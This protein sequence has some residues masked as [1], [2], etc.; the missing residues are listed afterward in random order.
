[1]SRKLVE[2]FA[3]PGDLAPGFSAV[4]RQRPLKLARL[5]HYP[6]KAIPII[7]SLS[8]IPD[9]GKVAGRRS[10]DFLVLPAT[11]T[12]R[13]SRIVQVGKRRDFPPRI[14]IALA[15]VNICPPGGRVVYGVYPSNNPSSIMF[16]PGGFWNERTLLG[17]K[18]GSMQNNAASTELYN[19]FRRELLRGFTAVKSFVVGPEAL[20]L[21]ESGGRLTVDAQA[22]PICDLALE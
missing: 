20:R 18:I 21:L 1:M 12:I 5:D 17:G 10:P 19:L 8:A 7:E 15:M 13:A 9:L 16:A 4:E 3:T 22:A 6:T 14:A 2:F 11:K